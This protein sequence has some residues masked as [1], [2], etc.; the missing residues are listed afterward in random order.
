MLPG[1]AAK[2]ESLNFVIREIAIKCISWAQSS[3]NTFVFQRDYLEKMKKSKN[4]H[5]LTT[6]RKK[7]LSLLHVNLELRIRAICGKID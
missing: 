6:V 7:S 3:V 2:R 4:Y 5:V 1:L